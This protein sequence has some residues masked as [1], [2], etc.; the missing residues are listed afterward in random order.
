MECSEEHRKKRGK[1]KEK[2]RI[3]TKQKK[4]KGMTGAREKESDLTR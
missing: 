2:W 1:K 3:K 4:K